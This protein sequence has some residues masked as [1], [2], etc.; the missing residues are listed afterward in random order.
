[1]KVGDLVRFKNLS[2]A[3]GELGLIT[4]IRRTKYGTGMISM[5]TESL[6]NCAIP[7]TK[8]SMYIKEIV[9]ER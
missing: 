9:S 3:W 4:E 6:H 7:W 8:R 1:M 5:L 2:S